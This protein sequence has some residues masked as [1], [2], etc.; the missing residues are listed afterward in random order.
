[1]RGWPAAIGAGIF[2]PNRHLG[3]VPT[4]SGELFFIDGTTEFGWVEVEQDHE[5]FTP[6]EVGDEKTQQP[7]QVQIERIR[8]FST[9]SY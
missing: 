9:D 6:S 5:T 8:R 7:D 1:M 3:G 4:S 2:R